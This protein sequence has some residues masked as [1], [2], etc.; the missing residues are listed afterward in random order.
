MLQRWD[1]DTQAKVAAAAGVSQSTVG[2]VLA[3][4]VHAHLDVVEAIAKAFGVHPITLLT[5][6]R[7]VALGSP[8]A[9][10]YAER[11]LL[12]AWRLLAPEQQHAVMGY[13][14][15]VTTRHKDYS[16][17]NKE[18]PAES[19]RVLARYQAP[20]G[21]RAAVSRAAARPPSKTFDQSLDDDASHNTT[22][23][24]SKKQRRSR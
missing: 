11:E 20:A 8:A 6:P 21:E 19:E 14:T 13:L 16:D 1:L 23:E 2:R 10:G 22:G 9:A 24:Q 18:T 3:A 17:V 12:S 4:D 5:D 7:D 15:V